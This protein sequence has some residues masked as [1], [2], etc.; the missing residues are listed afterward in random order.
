[1]LVLG[2][3]LAMVLAA[4]AVQPTAPPPPAGSG[5]AWGVSAPAPARTLDLGR[6]GALELR[7]DLRFSWAGLY[8]AGYSL[9]GEQRWIQTFSAGLTRGPLAGARFQWITVGPSPNPRERW[10]L[11]QGRH[12]FNQSGL[13]SAMTRLSVPLPNTN[14]E[15]AVQRP[16]G[17]LS[18]RGVGAP[19]RGAFI[20]G[21]F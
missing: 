1:M 15:L 10:N 11:G 13:P 6:L 19:A 7:T 2:S 14:L 21:K 8:G 17:L 5:P 9:S 20:S 4:P 18:P 3:I 16:V 12:R